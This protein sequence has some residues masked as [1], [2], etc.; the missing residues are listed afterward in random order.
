MSIIDRDKWDQR[1][2]DDS[3]RKNNPVD[4]I[5][6]WLPKIPVGKALDVACG[7]GRNALFLGHAGFA[8]D[9]IDISPVGLDRARQ[10]AAD[11]GLE[12]N[13]IEHD[14]DQAFDFD[15]DYQL[16]LVMWFVNLD[17]VE[18]LCRSLAP[19]GFLLSQEHLV[20]DEPV[21]GPRG[22]DFRVAPG[23]LRDAAAGLQLLLY[24]ESVDTVEDGDRLAS[25]RLVACRPG[26]G[27]G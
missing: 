15:R 24:E 8:V 13:W 2:T 7:A 10:Q 3:Y 22:S 19:G 5:V 17:L 6:D 9:A 18:R 12:I 14:L 20:S 11:E 26:S 4:M 16:I 25:A 23:A 21:I 27:G 1:Y